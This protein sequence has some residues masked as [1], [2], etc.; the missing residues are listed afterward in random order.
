MNKNELQDYSGVFTLPEQITRLQSN[1]M[2]GD[3]DHLV[4][5][6]ANAVNDGT[7]TWEQL[8]I[9]KEDFLKK[10][11]EQSDAY[12]GNDARGKDFPKYEELFTN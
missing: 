1:T 9:S 11:R 10:I 8:G 3:P 7:T 6:I 5:R 4:R 12:H 2:P